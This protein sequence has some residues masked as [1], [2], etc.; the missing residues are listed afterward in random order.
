MRRK[1]PTLVD[2]VT[3]AIGYG[4]AI[5]R[6]SRGNHG[7]GFGGRALWL[8]AVDLEDDMLEARTNVLLGPDCEP[9]LSEFFEDLAAH[10]KG[11]KGTKDWDCMD[12]LQFMIGLEGG[13]RDCIDPVH[14]RVGFEGGLKLSCTHDGLGHIAINVE[15]RPESGARWVARSFVAVHAGQLHEIAADLRRLLTVTEVPQR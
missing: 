11:W 9:S 3:V 12:S 2:P 10:W 14:G 4:D 8:V 15:L 6:L 7:P 5:L 1:T 13:F